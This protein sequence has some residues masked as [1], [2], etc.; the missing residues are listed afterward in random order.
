MPEI[1]FEELT[2]QKFKDLLNITERRIVFEGPRLNTDNLVSFLTGDIDDLFYDED[3]KKT[4]K[5]KIILCLDGSGSMHQ[6]LIDGCMA[7]DV[8]AGCAQQLDNILKEV[9]DLE[10]LNVTYLVRAFDEHYHKLPTQGW[11]ETYRHMNGGTNILRAVNEALKELH[12]GDI[13]GNKLLIL[14]TDGCVSSDEITE[15]KKEIIRQNENVKAMIIGVGAS[16]AGF[17]AREIIGDHNILT[18]ETA[19]QTVLETIM[20]MI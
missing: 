7:R 11:F 18:K 1:Y 3:V 4:K 15:I 5:S 2:K 10:G 12:Q 16:A 6:P 13:D 20:E 17:F 19:S 8:V 9:C 14:I